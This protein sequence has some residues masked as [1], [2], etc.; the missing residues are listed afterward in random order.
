LRIV[1]VTSD[2]QV[3]GAQRVLAQICNHFS[4]H[5]H[6]TILLTLAAGSEA[7]FFKLSGVRLLA[8]G[9]DLP[10]RGLK[11]LARVG[12]RIAAL[13]RTIVGSKSDIVISFMDVTNIM[14]LLATLGLAL[15]VIV[16]ERVD[17]A[18]HIHRLKLVERILRRLLYPRAQR[19][20]VQTRRAARFF[21]RFSPARLVTI[22]NPVPAASRCAR[23]GEPGPDRRFR[24]IGVGRLDRQKGFDL[25]I[26]SFAQLAERFPDW[27]VVIFGHGE[28]SASL[29][30]RIERQGLG[31]RIGLRVPTDDIAGELSRSHAMAFPSRYEGFPNALAEAMAAGLPAVAFEN[32]SGVEDLIAP[33]V[34]GILAQWGD[35]GTAAAAQSLAEGLGRLMA[36]ADL[37][38]RIGIAAAGHV[39][40]FAPE[41]VLA[42]WVELVASVLREHAAT[43]QSRKVGD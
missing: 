43:Q 13:R 6:H 19:I 32:V 3:G 38:T 15:P 2:M 16:S 24:I 1:C 12:K 4:V 37:R 28:E 25:L 14:V 33:G 29:Q 40:V 42:R 27:D 17:P 20:V 26:D 21:E 11:R 41:R 10:G 8:V 36:S 9:K 30:S 18:R 5:G 23:P 22:P 35:G 39:R 7:P 31:S 34:T